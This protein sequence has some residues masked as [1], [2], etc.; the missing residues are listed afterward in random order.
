MKPQRRRKHKYA[1][2]FQASMEFMSIGTFAATFMAMS[3][4][5]KAMDRFPQIHPTIGE[6][7]C[8]FCHCLGVWFRI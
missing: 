6:H 1:R 7:R 2:M 4:H 5:F 8:Q 3:I